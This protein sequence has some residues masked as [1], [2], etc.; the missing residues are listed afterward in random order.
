MKTSELIKKLKKGGCYFVR[1]GAGSHEVWFSPI[2][3]KHF[4]ITNHGAKEIAKGTENAI[5]KQAGLK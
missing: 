2:T 1:H 4:I 5:L 3:D